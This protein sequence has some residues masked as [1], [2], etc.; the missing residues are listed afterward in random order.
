[1]HPANDSSAQRQ[2]LGRVLQSP[3]FATVESLRRILK[4]LFD[5]SEDAGNAPP[6]E[7]EIAVEGLHRPASFDPKT[8]PIVRVNIAAIRTRLRNYFEGPGRSEP[9]CMTIPKGQYRLCWQERG[10]QRVGTDRVPGTTEACDRFW[11][12]YLSGGAPNILVYSELLFF[13]DNRGNYIRNIHVNDRT[14]GITDLKRELP[15]VPVDEL[16]PSFHFASAGEVKAILA[17]ERTFFDMQLSLNVRDSRFLSW[18]DVQKSNLI[19]LGS[20]RTNTFLSA[21]QGEECFVISDKC[22]DN[23][24][25]RGSEQKRYEGQRFMEGRL[26]REVEYAVV[27]RR[28]GVLGESA[29]T[30]IAANHGRAMQGAGEALASEEKLSAILEAMGYGPGVQLPARF[31]ILLRIDMLD[32]DEEIAWVEYLTH[33]GL[34]AKAS[35]HAT[36]LHR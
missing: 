36:E 2:L 7:Y 28:P 31:Q 22:I 15:E 20:S 30:V 13:R 10:A 4:Y 6:K 29:V 32:F 17:L 25:P 19:L 1:M 21:L 35:T 34:D 26:E 14:S 3:Q 9:V 23:V 33:R 5:R 24:D 16:R 12:P 8:D 27:T 18:A 11:R